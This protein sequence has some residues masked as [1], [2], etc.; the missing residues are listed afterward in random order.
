VAGVNINAY[1]TFLVPGF[2]PSN[3]PT[4]RRHTPTTTS[5]LGTYITSEAQHRCHDAFFVNTTSS[6]QA[7]TKPTRFRA[8]TQLHAHVQRLAVDVHTYMHITC[9]VLHIAPV[10]PCSSSSR[11]TNKFMPSNGHLLGD[12]CRRVRMH[13]PSRVCERVGGGVGG[14]PTLTANGRHERGRGTSEAM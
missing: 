5:L 13:T 6:G 1:V 3:S 4:I 12:R 8:L 14:G 11:R 9:A 10:V 2:K 7:A